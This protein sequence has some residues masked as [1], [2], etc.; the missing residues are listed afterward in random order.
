MPDKRTAA[1]ST[2]R[3][4]MS[5]SSDAASMIMDVFVIQTLVPDPRTSISDGALVPPPNCMLLP[6]LPSAPLLPPVCNRWRECALP[7]VLPSQQLLWPRFA[8]P[9]CNMRAEMTWRAR[10]RRP[11]T[12]G[13]P[14]VGFGSGAADGVRLDGA[15]VAPLPAAVLCVLSLAEPDGGCI[16]AALAVER[17]T[18]RTRLLIQSS[19]FANPSSGCATRTMHMGGS[20]LPS[21]SGSVSSQ[22]PCMCFECV[23][24]LTSLVHEPPRYI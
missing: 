13:K 15:C 18:T 10:R 21:N 17:V 19:T 5:G 6:L 12:R 8:R 14:N 22:A 23:C 1:S 3:A 7:S 9:S 20:K 4:R 11:L 16:A 24:N 2:L